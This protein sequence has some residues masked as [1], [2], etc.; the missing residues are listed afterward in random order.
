MDLNSEA[1]LCM[2]G[3]DLQLAFT[4]SITIRSLLPHNFTVVIIHWDPRNPHPC[5]WDKSLQKFLIFFYFQS[6]LRT[7]LQCLLNHLQINQTKLSIKIPTQN[8]IK[9]LINRTT[10]K[11]L[12]NFASGLS[13]SSQSFIQLVADNRFEIFYGHDSILWAS[14]A[15]LTPPCY[16]SPSKCNKQHVFVWEI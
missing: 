16:Q 9:E 11:V 1:S 2:S 14:T 5:A 15:L 8:Q 10:P 4:E 12:T 3:A 13:F 7:K 6:P